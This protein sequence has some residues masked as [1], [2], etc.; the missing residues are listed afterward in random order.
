MAI[1]GDPEGV[2]RALQGAP[3]PASEETSEPTMVL[4]KERL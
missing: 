1:A 2:L 4:K 3:T